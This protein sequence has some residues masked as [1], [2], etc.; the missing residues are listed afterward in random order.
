MQVRAGSYDA[1]A[2]V[3]ALRGSSYARFPA[4]SSSSGMGRPS[5][6]GTRSKTFSNEER[7]NVCIWNNCPAMPPISIPMRASGIIEKP[8]RIG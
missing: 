8:R 7:P 2:V 5:T 6:G 3:G 1:A 4:R